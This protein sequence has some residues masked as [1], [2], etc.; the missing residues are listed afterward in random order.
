MPARSPPVPARFPLGPRQCRLGPGSVPGDSPPVTVTVLAPSRSLLGPCLCRLGARRSSCQLAAGSVPA[1]AG[2]VTDS[3]RCRLDPH[4]SRCRLGR[5]RCRLDAGS[6]PSGAG[7]APTNVGSVPVHFMFTHQISSTLNG[8]ICIESPELRL[9]PSNVS[10]PL[11]RNL[12]V[13]LCAV[14]VQ[15]LQRVI[16]C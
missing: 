12:R 11:P 16:P 1:G 6:V 7:S 14:P 2:S 4:R 3:A 10:I 13:H 9:Y 8:S 15:L 5:S